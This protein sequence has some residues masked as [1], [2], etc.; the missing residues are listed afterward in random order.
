MMRRFKLLCFGLVPPFFAVAALGLLIAS[1]LRAQ[2]TP[3]TSDCMAGLQKSVSPAKVQP[4][5]TARVTMVIT[6]TCPD[7]KL[8]VDMVF[9]VDVSNSM[10]RGSGTKPPDSGSGAPTA[11]A[12]GPVPPPPAPP[13]AGADWPM[14][15]SL[16]AADSVDA[17]E[18]DP[19][20]PSPGLNPSPGG[21]L[22][23]DEPS[24]CGTST[25]SKPDPGAG[26]G[27]PTPLGPGRPVPTNTPCVG[28]TCGGP[29][30]GGIDPGGD[31]TTTDPEAAG[32]EDL[33]REARNFIRDFVDQPAIQK[34]LKSGHLRFGLAAFND[35]GRRLVSLSEDGKRITTRLGLLRGEGKTRIDL[36]MRKAEQV[37]DD[38]SSNRAT[39]DK[40]RVKVIVLISD[41]N[42]CSKD[43]KVKI[44]KDIRVVTLA[45]GRAAN[46]RKM[47]SM[48][49]ENEYALLLR[50]LKELVFLYEHPKGSKPI[51]QFR[52]VKMTELTLREEL[53][54]N[55]KLVPNSANPVPATVN[56]QKLD[57]IFP[58]PA[59]PITVTYDIQ[60]AEAGV[61]PI[62]A[63]SQ[64]EWRDSEKRT[65][66]GS[67][68]DTTIEVG[69]P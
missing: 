4:G 65:G 42:F 37:F 29:G 6:H 47:R 27:T 3:V 61:L 54:A 22:P 39:Q 7:Y 69:G 18:Q 31:K 2:T 66:R 44:S 48:A 57:W 63:S 14:L 36:G 62:S 60:P 49:S 55:Q 17:P 46:L 16:L 28:P 35:R 23:G 25:D 68:P 53:A 56:G 24:G 10:T 19:A 67:F 50:D 11:E 1:P 33:I 8:P 32:S 51:P 38:R 26:V 59:T 13:L 45:A 52:P 58:M 20:T 21:G 5:D 43:M 15:G 12:P 34:D 9:L 64:V 40:D 30:S 41:G